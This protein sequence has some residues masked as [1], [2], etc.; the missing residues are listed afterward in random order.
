MTTPG[1]EPEVLLVDYM[2]DALSVFFCPR[3]ELRLEDGR[4]PGCWCSEGTMWHRK[5][6]FDQNIGMI[7]PCDACIREAD[8]EL[9]SGP[10]IPPWWRD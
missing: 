7:G 6:R 1:N 9:E 10:Y 5:H 8:E 4:C 2:E 3:C